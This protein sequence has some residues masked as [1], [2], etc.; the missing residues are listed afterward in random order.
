MVKV[1]ITGVD[2]QLGSALFSKFASAVEFDVLGLTKQQ[3]DITDKQSVF[4][5]LEKYQPD[6]VVN[7]AAYTWVDGAE[8]ELEL[9][10]Q[11]NVT[12]AKHLAQ[13]CE[14]HNAVLLHFSTD[15]VFGGEQNQPYI[16][17]D[18]PQPLNHYGHSKLTSEKWVS[19]LC[20]KH[21][22]VRTSS[23]F[24]LLGNN[25]CRS[26]LKVAK[27]GKE[28]NVVADQVSAPTFVHDLVDTVETILYCL[29]QQ[30]EAFEHWGIYHY[31]GQFAISWYDFAL[32]VLASQ[33]YA[34]EDYTCNPI[35]LSKLNAKAKRPKYSVLDCT[36]IE[37]VF[38]IKTSD[39]RSA[40]NNNK[41]NLEKAVGDVLKRR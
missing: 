19:E 21:I 41:F 17:T 22:I 5:T 2:G 37:S 18:T 29:S 38:G 36:K 28:L 40:I 32:E 26:I 27:Q 9:C 24:S 10:T 34:A 8:T 15:Y 25:F 31:S 13:A 30:K 20:R 33:G 7:C 23:L 11:V 4:L 12:G 6:F 35:P 3:L 39:W 16:E 14:K 1:L